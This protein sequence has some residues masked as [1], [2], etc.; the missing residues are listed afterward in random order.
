MRGSQ[1]GCGMRKKKLMPISASTTGRF[2]KLLEQRGIGDE[3]F[4]KT[5]VQGVNRLAMYIRDATS[6]Q[7][8]GKATRELL[9]SDDPF[10]IRDGMARAYECWGFR[11]VEIPCPMVGESENIQSMREIIERQRSAGR[12]LIY[13]HPTIASAGLFCFNSISPSMKAASAASGRSGQVTR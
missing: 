9:L 7:E 11:D 13:V 5:C 4:A 2:A 12:L 10:E 6:I 8:G 3:V 1:R